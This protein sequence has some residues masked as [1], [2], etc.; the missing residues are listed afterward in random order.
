MKTISASE[1]SKYKL[2]EMVQ[3]LSN[4]QILFIYNRT[5]FESSI[6]D[7]IV[8]LMT[9][10]TINYLFIKKTRKGKIK[11]FVR[12]NEFRKLLKFI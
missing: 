4:N 8:L 1:F 5:K 3:N 9:D 6:T 7:N 10:P 11:R 12:G 2:N